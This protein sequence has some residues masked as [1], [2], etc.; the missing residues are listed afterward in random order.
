MGLPQ[1]IADHSHGSTPRRLVFRGKETTPEDGVDTESVKVICRNQR[2]P[3]TLRLASGG[4]AHLIDVE[5]DHVREAAI[6][7]AQV[8]VVRIGKRRGVFRRVASCD[9]NY[10]TG[11]R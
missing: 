9:G 8:N 10:I 1:A 2:S 7:I 5:T 6:A 4:E 3:N 11:T